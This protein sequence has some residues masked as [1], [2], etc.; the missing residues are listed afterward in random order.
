MTLTLHIESHN[1]LEGG[2]PARIDVP[3]AG[4]RAGRSGSMDWI[5][6]DA[7]RHIS[8]HHF[9]VFRQDDGWWLRDQSTNGTF[10]QGQRFRLDGPHRLRNGD[11]F[12]VG[13]YLVTALIAG[14]DPITAPPAPLTADSLPDLSR[15]A[16][17]APPDWP[18]L[19]PARLDFQNPAAA[20]SSF[21]DLPRAP[22][23]EVTGI[24]PPAPATPSSDIVTAFCN[25]AGLPPDLYTQVDGPALALALGQAVRRVSEQIMLSLQDRAAAK[26]FA[27]A[28]EGTMQADHDNN[29][30]K[31]LPSSDQAIE[32]MFLRPRPGFLTGPQGLDAA[33]SDLRLH[34]AAL[35]AALQPALAH[36][37]AD[38]DPDDIEAEAET[39]RQG[40]NRAAKAWEIFVRRWR[41]KSEPHDNGMADEFLNLFAAAYRD[42]IDGQPAPDQPR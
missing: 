19:R 3:P 23:H 16:S 38:L 13:P 14:E 30:L 36:L 29:P 39:N 40:G 9:D 17:A 4:L 8:G 1:S 15:P 18:A 33:L 24:K 42:A 31:F 28:G 5:L 22:R 26:Q 37:L 27:R 20:D 6:S 35:F 25:G 11:R 7:S 21:G 10:L 2:T 41:A 12:Q 32:A 34:H